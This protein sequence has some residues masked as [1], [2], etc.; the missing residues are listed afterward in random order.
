MNS[1]ALLTLVY[2]INFC[3]EKTVRYAAKAFDYEDTSEI[4]VI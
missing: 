4:T 1:K 3:C 2:M